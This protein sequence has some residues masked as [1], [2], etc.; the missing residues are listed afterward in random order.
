MLLYMNHDR[1]KILFIITQSEFGGAQRFLVEL[2]THLDVNRFEVL[3]A[4]GAGSGGLDEALRAK[5]IRSKT[6]K[7]LT[8]NISPVHD[9]MAVFEIQGL[10]RD[11]RPDIIF[12]L[13]SKAGFLGSLA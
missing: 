4:S 6:L 11:E 9:L 10:L 1:K 13:S 3:V 5:N 12:L 2:A 8:R 7:W